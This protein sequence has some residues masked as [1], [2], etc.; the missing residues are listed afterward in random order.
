MNSTKKSKDFILYFINCSSW[1]CDIRQVDGDF[2]INP[3]WT[4]D[5]RI[6]L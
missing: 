4:L 5:F 6:L 3:V 1:K 2:E